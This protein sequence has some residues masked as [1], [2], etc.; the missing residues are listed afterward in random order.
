L[1]KW[2]ENQEKRVKEQDKLFGKESKPIED[3]NKPFE[4]QKSRASSNEIINMEEDVFELVTETSPPALK[5]RF[6][7]PFV[8]NTDEVDGEREE[9][10]WEDAHS[11][12]RK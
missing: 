6:G 8:E 3:E 5:N 2:T 4:E 11:K 12:K 7:A 10:Y 9:A 1:R